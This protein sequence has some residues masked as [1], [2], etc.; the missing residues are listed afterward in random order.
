MNGVMTND[1][2]IIDADGMGGLIGDDEEG[3]RVEPITDDTVIQL[4]EWATD[5]AYQLPRSS[6]LR[7]VVGSAATAVVRVINP[8]VLPHH[9]ELAYERSRWR[10]SALDH[11]GAL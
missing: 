3:R 2:G 9:A 10:V 6:A 7:C 5:R 11:K 8:S 4:R 1:L